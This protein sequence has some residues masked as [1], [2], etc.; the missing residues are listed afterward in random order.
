MTTADDAATAPRAAEVVEHHWPSEGPYGPSRTVSAAP[1]TQFLLR[2]VHRATQQ[3]AVLVHPSTVTDTLGCVRGAVYG[4]YHLLS[5]LEY[6]YTVQ[7]ADNP[8]LFDF[9]DDPNH[10]AS[11]TAGEAAAAMH[12]A[13]DLAGQLATQ[14]DRAASYASRLGMHVAD[15]GQQG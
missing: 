7:A 3:P 13:R 4:V 14:L 1:A 6:W 8:N 12:A 11:K 5:T 15:E 2:Y 10:P 9:R